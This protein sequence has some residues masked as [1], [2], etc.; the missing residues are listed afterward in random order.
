MNIGNST[1][2]PKI[3]FQTYEVSSPCASVP[4]PKRRAV[5]HCP[6][7]DVFG[8]STFMDQHNPT[9]PRPAPS[10]AVGLT[11]TGASPTCDVAARPRWHASV[12]TS[13]GP[14]TRAVTARVEGARASS[15]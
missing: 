5:L 10:L 6:T 9:R 13:E 3:Q 12:H 2:L 1:L 8:E 15:C 14:G 4:R 7:C 11:E